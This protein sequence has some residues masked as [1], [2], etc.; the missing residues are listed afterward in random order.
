VSSLFEPISPFV[1]WTKDDRR[2]LDDLRTQRSPSLLV[3]LMQDA[4]AMVERLLGREGQGAVLGSL[5]VLVVS[6]AFFAVVNTSMYS[7]ADI[8]LGALVAP[9]D[10]LMSI[11]ASLGPIYAAGLLLAARI[12]L[13][14]LVG[15]LMA[16]S[17]HGALVLAAMT[18]IPYF[19]WRADRMYWG[20]GALIIVFLISGIAAG[21]RLHKM[22][23]RLAQR[24]R[25]A[26]SDPMHDALTGGEVFRVGILARVSMMML[27]FTAALA[28]WGF[29]VFSR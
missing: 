6:S 16:A 3:D 21:A 5:L 9:L 17:A 8:A 12:P 10:A 14:R 4:D 2:S 29:D 22:M 23:H 28:F 24:I 19:A 7:S 20:P 18:P 27:A 1:V 11:A 25:Y 15:V 26:S 13:G